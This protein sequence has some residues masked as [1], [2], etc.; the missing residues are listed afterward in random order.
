[1][2]EAAHLLGLSITA[3]TSLTHVYILKP[4]V[5]PDAPRQYQLDARDIDMALAGVNDRLSASAL[6][7]AT[8]AVKD[9]VHR[10]NRYNITTGDILT[11]IIE[12]RVPAYRPSELPSSHLGGLLID[13]EALHSEVDV[14][15]WDTVEGPV[16]RA[17]TL[18]AYFANEAQYQALK[19]TFPEKL[20]TLEHG[21]SCFCVDT[22]KSLDNEYLVLNRYCGM[23]RLNV[24]GLR[25]ALEE[26]G[27]TPAFNSRGTRALFIY[28][29]TEE[30]LSTLN[31]LTKGSDFEVTGRR[32]K[33]VF[34]HA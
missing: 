31:T 15:L 32:N 7:G 4:L 10:L 34:G 22:L 3:L 1:M 12:G 23:R 27:F 26:A 28:P 33:R 25:D 24:V 19:A 6:S 13:R 5:N 2:T 8:V 29:R 17:T 20:V 21:R 14:H 9:I 18:K 11:W 16:K 30:L